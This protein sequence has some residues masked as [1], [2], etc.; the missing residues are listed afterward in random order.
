MR[1]SDSCPS[2]QLTAGYFGASQLS[3]L[4]PRYTA[5]SWLLRCLTAVNVPAPL[6]HVEQV[7]V[8]HVTDGQLSYAA[9]QT[10]SV[11]T[12]R[13]V[14][15]VLSSTWAQYDV[16]QLRQASVECCI[17]PSLVHA[18]YFKTEFMRPHYLTHTAGYLS[19]EILCRTSWVI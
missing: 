15:R 1:S 7:D 16:I 6:G 18:S 5:D 2:T 12:R 8:D 19:H 17:S 10:G 13:Q 14:A 3:M 11:A 4:L 9:G